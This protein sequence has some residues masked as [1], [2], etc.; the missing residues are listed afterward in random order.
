M[1]A[2]IYLASQSPRRRELLAQIGVTH[3]LLPV[4]VDESRRADEPAEVY[5]QRLASEKAGAGWKQIIE[6]GL[7][8]LPVLGADTA[9]VLDGAL[10]GKPTDAADA[11]AILERLSGRTHE[12]LTGVAV[13]GSRGE[14]WAVSRTRVWF[15]PL[16]AVEIDRYWAS[17]EPRDKAGAYGIQGRAAIFIE[18]IEG[19]YS[20]VVGLP[21]FETAALLRR[22]GIFASGESCKVQ[23]TT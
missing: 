22:Y 5:V 8:P 9:V 3:R 6:T 16:S 15:R 7:A 11:H 21:L 23:S 19:S 12:V 20:G 10:L 4:A 18:R 1:A 13:R 17:G 14:Q 2:D